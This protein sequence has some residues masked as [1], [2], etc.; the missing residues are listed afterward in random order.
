[1]E[2]EIDKLY[3]KIPSEVKDKLEKLKYVNYAK[4]RVQFGKPIGKNQ[5]ISHM[6]AD[7]QAQLDAV[8][9]WYTVPRG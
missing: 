4:E 8:R 5:A 9:Y 3:E 1:V 6:L 2:R 7:L